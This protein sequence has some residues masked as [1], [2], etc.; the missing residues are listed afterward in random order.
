M[1]DELKAARSKA[2][3]DRAKR[4]QKKIEAEQ[5]ERDTANE[6]AL[7]D[8]AVAAGQTQ[9]CGCC[10]VDTPLNKLVACEGHEPHYFCF[11]CLKGLAKSQIELQKYEI[12]CMDTNHNCKA[13]FSRGSKRSCLDPQTLEKLE[14]IQQKAELREAGLADLVHCPFCNFGGLCPPV[15]I[16]REFRCEGPNCGR[17]SCRLC[18]KDTHIPKTCEENKKDI[19]ID[20]RHDVEEAMTDAFVRKCPKCKVPIMKDEGCN[21]I[22]CSCGTMICDVC[23]KDITAEGYRHFG[24]S[25]DRTKCPQYDHDSEGRRAKERVEAAEKATKARIRAENP[26][27]SEADL[28]I[29]FSEAVKAD[30]KK[31]LPD[32]LLQAQ[33]GNLFP[34]IPGLYPNGGNMAPMAHMLLHQYP[35]GGPIFPDYNH[36]GRLAHGFNARFGQHGVP[37]DFPYNEQFAGLY[38]L[39]QMPPEPPRFED[40]ALAGNRGHDIARQMIQERIARQVAAPEPRAANFFE[41]E[42]GYF[43]PRGPPVVAPQM[44]IPRHRF[45]GYDCMA[46][47]VIL[48][49]ERPAFQL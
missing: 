38:G 43:R 10:F 28:D 2:T 3:K 36:G 32:Q 44:D 35:H 13:G 18:E 34:A 16:D 42:P 45:S 29:K 40:P 15:E 19:G 49:L 23:G 8:A 39:P 7:D 12:L 5:K 24:P 11:D 27:I 47:R 9:E 31:T 4:Q 6:K 17:V 1:A 20:E 14:N 48:T 22:I 21:K 30:G 26:D 37:F 41:N 25:P 46:W 33:G